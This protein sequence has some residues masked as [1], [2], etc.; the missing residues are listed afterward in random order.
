MA[1]LDDDY[2]IQVQI[3]AAEN[4]FLVVFLVGLTRLYLVFGPTLLRNLIL[5]HLILIKKI[6]NKNILHKE[7]NLC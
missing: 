7:K 1:I 2:R 6:I 3:L 4:S 5:A